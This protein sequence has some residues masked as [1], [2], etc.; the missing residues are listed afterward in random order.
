MVVDPGAIIIIA[1][2]HFV[3]FPCLFPPECEYTGRVWYPFSSERDVIEKDKKIFNRKAL[4]Y[5]P[6]FQL[7]A[8]CTGYI[9]CLLTTYV[10]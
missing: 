1:L 8:Q 3:A 2:I 6:F 7:Y 10:R 5:T 9:C 4:F